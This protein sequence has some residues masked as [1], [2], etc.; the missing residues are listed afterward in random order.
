MHKSDRV[1]RTLEAADLSSMLG[2]SCHEARLVFTALCTSRNSISLRFSGPKTRRTRF[3]M[4]LCRDPTDDRMLSSPRIL[5]NDPGY[6]IW[7]AFSSCWNTLLFSLG[8]RETIRSLPI[9]FVLKTG[10]Y[11][12]SRSR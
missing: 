9:K 7:K 2:F 12:N 1:E 3:L 11:L 5:M 6:H 10:P 8:S 4:C